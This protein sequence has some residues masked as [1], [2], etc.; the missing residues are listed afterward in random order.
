MVA[1][2]HDQLR[3]VEAE[4]IERLMTPVL[5]PR[6][7]QHQI[8][9]AA[10]RVLGQAIRCKTLLDGMVQERIRGRQHLRQLE[11][12]W[13]FRCASLVDRGEYGIHGHGAVVGYSVQLFRKRRYTGFAVSSTY[14]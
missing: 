5:D 10:E 13:Q 1:R 3:R 11:G 7:L 9:H 2:E 12:G 6:K 8:F 14:G 4:Q